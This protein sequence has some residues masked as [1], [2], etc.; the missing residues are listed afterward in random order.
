VREAES[1]A[2]LRHPAVVRVMEFAED[3]E[4]GLLYLVMELAE[5]ETL[6]ERLE[7]GPLDL[8]EALEMF[9]PLAQGLEHAHNCGVYHRDIKPSNIVLC[10]DRSVRLVDFG[11]SAAQHAEPLTNSGRL[12]TLA[13]LPPEAFKG[14]KSKPARADV[15]GFGLVAYETLTGRRSFRSTRTSHRPRR[16]R[17]WAYARSN[18]RARW[19]CPN[20]SR[21]S[22]A[23]WCV[24]RPRRTRRTALA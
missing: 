22:C 8:D 15:Y 16:R 13:Y 9:L 11:I 4:R 18:S 17:P 14:E 21:C 19:S 20:T 10:A 12:G 2:A 6:R 23:S 3:S 5:G 24:R 7:R 1:L